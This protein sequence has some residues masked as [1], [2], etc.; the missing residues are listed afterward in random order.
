MPS[1]S[2]T[3]RVSDGQLLH[4]ADRAKINATKSGQL[5]IRGIE[6]STVK[7]YLRHFL[8]YQNYLFEF[9]NAEAAKPSHVV[10]LEHCTC[11]RVGMK[12]IH[13]TNNQVSLL[14]YANFCKIF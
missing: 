4:L 8:L 1:S 5:F 2:S 9:A 6:G 3:I 7:W 14:V 13:D 10:F 11:E 12:T